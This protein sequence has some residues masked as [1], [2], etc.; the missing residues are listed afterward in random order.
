MVADVE[1]TGNKSSS[2]ENFP[3][4]SG[5]ADLSVC[6]KETDDDKDDEKDDGDFDGSCDCSLAHCCSKF[7]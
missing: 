6:V 2:H 5:E 3:H 7:L 4:G 1:K